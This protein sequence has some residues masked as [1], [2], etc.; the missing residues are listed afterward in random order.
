M[1]GGD[2]W[3][4]WM[5]DGCGGGGNKLGGVSEMMLEKK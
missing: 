4:R 3:V 2:G 5:V 1:E